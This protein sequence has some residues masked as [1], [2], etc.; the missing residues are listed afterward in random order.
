MATFEKIYDLSP[1][2]LQNLMCSVS[3]KIKYTSRYGT[4]Y[5]KARQFCAKFDS[6]SLSKQKRYQNSQLLEFIR[7]ADSHS[8]FYHELYAGIDLEKI[9]TVQD[10]SLLPIVDKEML[11][12][13]IDEVYTLGAKKSILGNTG[14]TT[15]KSLVVRQTRSDVMTRMA[16]LDHFKSRVGFENL[17]MRRATFNGK[18]IIPPSQKRPVY[19]RYN[20]PCRQMIYSSFDLTED[21]MGYYVENLNKFKPQALDG[22]FSSI[23]DIASY[24]ERHDA[25]LSFQ[26]VAVFPTSETLTEAGRA[27]IERVFKCKVYDQYASSEGAPFVTE[28]R[29]QTL[30]VELNTG[31]FEFLEDGEILITS[32]TTHGTPL[33]RYA[34]GDKM[35]K[36]DMS[37]TCQCGLCGPIIKRIDGRKLDFLYRPDGARINA[38]NVSNLLKYLPSSVI[39]TQFRQSKVDELTILIEVDRK[40]FQESDK[41]KL[42]EECKHTFGHKMRVTINGVD[43]IPRADSG[44]FRM[45][46]N[47]VKV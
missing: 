25:K 8:K 40:K 23:C 29:Y 30:H 7:F 28:C 34:I 46:I 19:W 1:I 44:K 17:K 14:G 41:T 5:W 39:R 6:W 9:K 33:I 36:G 16:I 24:I 45:I 47:S 37:A 18:H 15:G 11:R 12:E 42:L 38:G 27:L 26:P 4:E 21:K 13:H 20:A 22:F 31:V 10:L 43:S 32:F 35:E 3:G 2:F